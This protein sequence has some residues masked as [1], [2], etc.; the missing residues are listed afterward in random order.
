[1]AV[2]SNLS[3][4][5]SLNSAKLRQGLDKAN[6]QTKRF[7]KN[8][9]K[10]LN[11]V[12]KSFNAM[13][14]AAVAAFATIGSAA[15]I[16][17]IT[18]ITAN[19]EDLRSALST[20]FGSVSEGAAQFKTIMKLADQTGLP[21]KELSS[22]FIKLKAAG[23]QP[24]TELL[25]LFADVANSTTDKIGAL[26]S[27]TDLWA[28]TTA[29]G[30]GL[31]DLNRLAD[32][33]IPVFTIFAEKL[34]V[35]RLE[36][37]KVGQTAE[38]ASILLKTLKTEF[39]KTLGGSSAAKANNL[40]VVLQRTKNEFQS[41]A[42]T[43]GT[44]AAPGIIAFNN[45]IKE[46]FGDTGNLAKQLGQGLGKAAIIVGS[47]LTALAENLSTITAAI[48][49]AVKAWLVF[50]AVAFSSAA[51]TAMAAVISSFKG[52]VKAVTSIR[53]A[54]RLAAGS[55]AIFQAVT[56]IGLAKLIAGAV[57]AGG[58]L[59][60]LD[61]AFDDMGNTATKE[62][63][64]INKQLDT[65]NKQ[66]QEKVVVPDIADPYAEAKKEIA[67]I[68]KLNKK[69]LPDSL[70][71]ASD[72]MKSFKSDF[73]TNLL[74]LVKGTK[75]IGGFMNGV[76]DSIT[77]RILTNFTENITNTLLK[78]AG[79]SDGMFGQ[80]LGSA[81]KIDFGSLA[82]MGS[83][84]F[85]GASSSISTAFASFGGFFADGGRPPANRPSVVGE[86]G[87]EIFVPD[88]AGTIIPNHDLGGK[89]TTI[90]LNVTGNVDDATRRSIMTM[91]PEIAEM[92]NRTND[93][94]GIT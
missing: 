42:D 2:V 54:Y 84:F 67:E 93:E 53:T 63:S 89:S 76:L 28:R 75:S 68:S 5:L 87:P 34:G 29:G 90:N 92:V 41:L 30:L 79:G 24:T 48:S 40:S 80:M 94:R 62:L 25:T 16:S 38:G 52:L 64:E 78:Q 66:L 55:A 6:G 9:K 44:A 43:I 57:A 74:E 65:T 88:S 73:N 13:Q 11:G 56:G 60:V 58:A 7:G 72:A 86:R 36:L 15:A 4:S 46:A 33:G 45:S 12:T 59:Y 19:F 47:L 49:L 50:K 35:S 1:M 85:S 81:G 10:N 22:A 69:T 82:S 91:G 14:K 70:K 32:R 20:V 71:T 18:R 21:I 37:S 27:I 39:T 83:S 8:A 26:Q 23:I 61:K 51:I 77:N 31:E 3:V 17:S